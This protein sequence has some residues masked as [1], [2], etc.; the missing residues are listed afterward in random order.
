MPRIDAH[1]HFWRYDAVGVRVDR[2]LHDALAA[3]LPAR[4]CC[5]TRCAARASTRCVAVQARQTLEETRWLLALAD[6]HPFIA[7]VVGWV[8]LQSDELDAQ[9][10][11]A[12]SSEARRRPPHRP[13][14][15]R[16]LSRATLDSAGVSRGSNATAWPTTSWSTR[17]SSARPFDFASAFPDQRFV[18]DHLGKPDI[19]GGAFDAW[20]RDL[21]R[22][23]ALPNVWAKLSGL[24]TE[25][26]WRRW[27]SGRICIATST[28][29]SRLWCRNG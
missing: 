7:G 1:Q 4:G 20:R 27:T 24:V 11:A 25:A 28:P 2:R 5:R 9:I 18:L 26:D 22:L 15:S 3:R 16:R 12:A 19:R 21:D 10:E 23:A 6:E 13:G 17:G 29:R 14:G 8:D